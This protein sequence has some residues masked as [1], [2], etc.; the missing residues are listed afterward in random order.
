MKS[1]R[2]RC[3]ARFPLPEAIELPEPKSHADDRDD[4]GGDQRNP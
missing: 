2:D 4:G 1:G 3:V